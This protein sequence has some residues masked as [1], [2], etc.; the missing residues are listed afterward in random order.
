MTPPSNAIGIIPKFV[1]LISQINA[2]Q[3]YII[4]IHNNGDLIFHLKLKA[5]GNPIETKDGLIIQAIVEAVLETQ[6]P[7]I[8]HNAMTDSQF[9]NEW[10]VMR[11]QVRSVMCVPL[12]QKDRIGSLIYVENRSERG[13]FRQDQIPLLA[14]L[15]GETQPGTKT[16]VEQTSQDEYSD[17]YASEGASPPSIGALSQPPN[18][19]YVFQKVIGQGGMGIVHQAT[20]RLTGGTVALK[21]VSVPIENFEFMSISATI[22][23]QSH[24]LA[25]MK[26]FQTLASLRHPHII[27][28]LDYGFDAN[29]QPYFTMDYL[30]EAQTILGAGVALDITGKIGLIQQVLQALVYL[31]RRGVI[32][33]DLKPSNILVI[34][35]KAQVL[36]FGLSINQD[37]TLTPAG[38]SLRYMAPELLEGEPASFTSDLYAV[39]VIA[40]ELFAGHHPFDATSPQFAEQVINDLPDLSKLTVTEGVSVVIGR[41]LAK[42]PED[43]YQGA[44]DC[45]SALNT[46]LGQPQ[47]EDETI[48]ES[49]LQAATFVGRDTEMAQL[50]EALAQAKSEQGVIYLL[51][52]ESGVGKSRLLDE[53]RLYALING[54]QV[55]AGQAI[56]ER[57]APYQLWQETVLRL[58]L[59]TELS[60][61]EARVL[62]EIAPSLD[63]L[64]GHEIPAAPSLNGVEREQRLVLIL[65]SV[66]QRQQHPTLLVLEDLQWANESLAPLQH[67]LKVLDQLPG[68]MVVGTYRNDERPDMPEAL[69]GAE[70]MPLT[71]LN[72][73]AIVQLSQAMLGEQASHDALISLLQHETEGNTFFIVEVMR[74]LAEDAG[75]LASVGQLTLPKH[76]LTSGMSELLQRRLQSVS[77]SDHV[78]LSLAAV[79]G[80]HIDERLLQTLAPDVPIKHWLHRVANRAVLLVR[81]NQWQFSHDKLRETILA[82]LSPEQLRNTHRQVAQTLELVYGDDVRYNS[83]LLAHWQ[84]AASDEKELEYLLLVV[85]QMIEVSGDYE[86][87]LE[88]ARRGLALLSSTDKRRITLL[89][90]QADVY[91]REAN[92]IEG[93]RVANAAYTLAHEAKDEREQAT[94][95]NILGSIYREQSRYS[96]AHDYFQQALT[97]GQATD[98][99]KNKADS[100]LQLGIVA[101]FQKDYDLAENYFQQ[102][103]TLCRSIDDQIGITHCF[104]YLG[105][106]AA[107]YHNNFEASLDYARQSLVIH[108][109]IGNQRNISKTL[110]SMGIDNAS[111]GNYAAARN[112]FEQSLAIK[113]S[114]G[115]PVGVAHTYLVLGEA[116]FFE[117]VDHKK[118]LYY[119]EQ[120]L[121]IYLELNAL[122]MVG[123]DYGYIALSHV[124]LGAYETAIETA[125]NHFELQSTIELDKSN[126]LV[127]VA[128]AK[129]LVACEA[130]QI[131]VSA[132]QERIDTLTRLTQLAATPKAYIKEAER[133]STI[134]QIR[135]VVLIECGQLALQIGDQEAA[136][137]YLSEAKV[138]A[139]KAQNQHKLGQIETLGF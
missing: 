4:N 122:A 21:Q 72:D 134:A 115:D 62:K 51:G 130:G 81:D 54:W 15:G 116:Y 14:G 110:T 35:G 123:I 10:D 71:R 67:M 108:Q 37:A 124:F 112:Y 11:L 118:A 43:R 113:E 89:N 78:L 27:S 41:L 114:F 91:A 79:A 8:V 70:V 104:F 29:Q 64:L 1:N 127:H 24:Q 109:A 74:A 53:F 23:R 5:N 106:L 61:L 68:V 55:L 69:S 38:G 28:V 135:L 46:A 96:E 86:S 36:D 18:P 138:M 76:I 40:F 13:V 25:L 60:D 77:E 44:S 2:E 101:E 59:N 121:Q 137:T 119:H 9:A 26:E 111:T 105:M 139:E 48:R 42:Q 98:D 83:R 131:E 20:D 99:V 19:R 47:V 87:G 33:R 65:V 129:I 16:S 93:E 95:L 45:L 39:G 102:S 125:L 50:K 136:Q 57:S 84:A 30:A 6:N 117:G 32:H 128:V 52:G 94:S 17:P 100:L 75:Q 97:M 12:W 132:L 133:V 126:G 90:M 80:R 34:D 107:Q 63:T 58:A 3:G 92:F 49:F 82:Q 31:H 73:T 7:V 85:K 88:L 120:S 66:L 22:T 56:T 103:L